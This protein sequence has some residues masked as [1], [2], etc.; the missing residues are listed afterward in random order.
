MLLFHDNALVHKCNIVQAAI[1]KAGF[2]E[3]NHPIYSADIA[4][5]DYY[6]FSNLKTFLR[7]KNFSRD[8]EITDTVEDY[9]NKLDC[10]FFVKEYQVC[11]AAGGM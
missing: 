10:E 1:R 2:I 9:F 4:A 11:L 8:D 7:S 6:L 5:S 3:L